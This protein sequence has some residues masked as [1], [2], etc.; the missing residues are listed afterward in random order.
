MDTNK[1]FHV[2][3]NY[4]TRQLQT[5]FIIRPKEKSNGVHEKRPW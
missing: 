2:N 5:F 3:H 4:S 1:Q